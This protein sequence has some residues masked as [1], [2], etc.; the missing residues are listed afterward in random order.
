[1]LSYVI[2]LAIA[3][4]SPVTHAAKQR[5]S[6]RSLRRI[7]IRASPLPPLCHVILT[8]HDVALRL[9]PDSRAI[10]N[11]FAPRGDCVVIPTLG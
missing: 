6:T 1:M 9:M 2:R 3:I 8:F 11:Y 10:T 4:T 5:N 7:G